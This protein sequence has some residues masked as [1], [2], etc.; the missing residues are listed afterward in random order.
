MSM[1]SGQSLFGFFGRIAGT[2]ISMVVSITIW[3]IVDQKTAGVIVFLWLAILLMMYFFLKFP[4]FI[5]I[6]I[7]S[8]V[9]LVLITGYQLQGR[10]IGLKACRFVLTTDENVTDDFK[11]SQSGQP[12]Y[13]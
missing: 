8:M 10:N 6:F 11:A 5:P 12:Y 13:P 2:A 9:T 3:Y 4:R 7:I 1:T